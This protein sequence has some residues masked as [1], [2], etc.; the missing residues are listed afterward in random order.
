MEERADVL[1]FE[2]RNPQLLFE[3]TPERVLSLLPRLDVAAWKGDRAGYHLP[4]GLPLLREHR[5]LLEDE[6]RDALKRVSVLPHG[7]HSPS[8]LASLER[9]GRTVMNGPRRRRYPAA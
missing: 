4:R 3:L 6:G 9:L 5:R 7:A 8:S 1:Y 2:G